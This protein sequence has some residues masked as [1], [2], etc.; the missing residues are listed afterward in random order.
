MF[1]QIVKMFLIKI[2]CL[3]QIVKI[4]QE[5]VPKI[6]LISR[7]GQNQI[8]IMKL[9]S[10]KSKYELKY[11]TNHFCFYSSKVDTKIHKSY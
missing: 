5:L 11:E 9:S 2:I 6:N 4:I 3:L 10:K 7:N 1:I 8:I